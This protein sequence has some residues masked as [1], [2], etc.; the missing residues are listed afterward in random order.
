MG[1]FMNNVRYIDNGVIDYRH[2]DILTIFV[3]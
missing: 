3:S 1:I 2:A